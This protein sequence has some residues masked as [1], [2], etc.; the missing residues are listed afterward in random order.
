[1]KV[2]VSSSGAVAFDI[3]GDK[4]VVL[5]GASEAS[6]MYDSP[7]SVL[8]DAGSDLEIDSKEFAELAREIYRGYINET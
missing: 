1:M 2:Y 3:P 5:Y 7:H 6:V 4:S 8:Y